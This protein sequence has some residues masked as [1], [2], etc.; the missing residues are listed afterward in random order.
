MTRVSCLTFLLSTLLRSLRH[1]RP[2]K[3]VKTSA[4]ANPCKVT[5]H[6]NL[7]VSPL[8][9]SQTYSKRAYVQFGHLNTLL[10]TDIA[11][12]TSSRPDSASLHAA[13]PK[14]N[15]LNHTSRADHPQPAARGSYVKHAFHTHRV[16]SQLTPNLTL[17]CFLTPP[18]R[19]SLGPHPP[20]AS[21]PTSHMLYALSFVRF[22]LSVYAHAEIRAGIWAASAGSWR[23]DSRIDGPR[24]SPS[25]R[26]SRASYA[27]RTF[28][29]G[30][31]PSRME[32][33]AS[34]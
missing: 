10:P 29:F 28:A 26:Y 16:P 23:I 15:P 32:A 20:F 13:I 4:P 6:L 24:Y 1:S 14:E 22:H 3:K 33:G 31:F 30:R 34:D 19:F 27:H 25:Y 12:P 7:S 2:S 9:R 21:L 5:T 17:L 18:R 8:T 11:H